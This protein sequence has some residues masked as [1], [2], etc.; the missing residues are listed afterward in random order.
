MDYST[1]KGGKGRRE[2]IGIRNN[3][4]NINNTKNTR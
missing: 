4:G 1:R 3:D 2:S